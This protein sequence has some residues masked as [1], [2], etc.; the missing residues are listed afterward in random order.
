MKFVRSYRLSR[1]VLYLDIVGS[2]DDLPSWLNES[3]YRLSMYAVVGPNSNRKHDFAVT[4]CTG[5]SRS[6]LLE[7]ISLFCST[8]KQMYQL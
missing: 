5:F 8:L 3:G 6:F 4:E 2:D 1:D 7:S